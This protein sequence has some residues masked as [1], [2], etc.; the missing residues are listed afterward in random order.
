MWP[1]FFQCGLRT[2]ITCLDSLSF[3]SSPL[4]HRLGVGLP[5]CFAPVVSYCPKEVSSAFG[6]FSFSV[7]FPFVPDFFF[8]SSEGIE[9][10]L[11][12]ARFSSRPSSFS[13]L[14]ADLN[15]T[16]LD[17]PYF[18]QPLLFPRRSFFLML[19]ELLRR[20][21]CLRCQSFYRKGATS[22]F[23]QF[24]RHAR[25]SPLLV[26]LIA[27]HK[28]KVSILRGFSSSVRARDGRSF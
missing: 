12:P 16:G 11:F 24:R 21:F 28:T 1:L 10:F 13:P 26:P 27:V 19:F 6:H 3:S 5:P 15:S 14:M 8:L 7:P 17:V 2:L 18:C 23:S 22:Q 25:S 9:R 20:G 4:S